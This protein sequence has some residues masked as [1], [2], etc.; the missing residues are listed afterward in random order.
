MP[1]RVASERPLRVLCARGASA[2]WCVEEMGPLRFYIDSFLHTAHTCALSPVTAG[3]QGGRARARCGAPAPPDPARPGAR[4]VRD[5]PLP[6]RA[7]WS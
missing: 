2:A 3:G 1:W 7:R 6:A 5:C 4:R